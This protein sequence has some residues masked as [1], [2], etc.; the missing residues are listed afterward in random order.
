MHS[1]Q[2]LNPALCKCSCLRGF[3]TFVFCTKCFF[4]VPIRNECV[5]DVILVR[6][7]NMDIEL[8]D[9]GNIMLEFLKHLGVDFIW[10]FALHIL[11]KLKYFTLLLLKFCGFH[12]YDLRC[13]DMFVCK[14]SCR[15]L[16]LIVNRFC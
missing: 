5:C 12:P 14:P 6:A 2:C 7:C 15:W 3:S 10:G 9:I 13:R 4:G 1:L 8:F 11:M 16:Q